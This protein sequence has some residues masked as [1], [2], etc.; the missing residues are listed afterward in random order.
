MPL[1]WA[2]ATKFWE[3]MVIWHKLVALA[4]AL[5]LPREV[6]IGSRKAEQYCMK[7][8]TH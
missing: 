7:P 8:I 4:D 1:L 6:P 2:D 3:N 5:L